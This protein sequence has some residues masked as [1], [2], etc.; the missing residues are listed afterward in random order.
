MTNY[1]YLQSLSLKDL[2]KELP[3]L[4]IC[5]VCKYIGDCE[6]CYNLR[7]CSETAAKWLKAERETGGRN[8]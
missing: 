7:N 4:P 1:E 3:D 5:T 2:A 6:E 8:E